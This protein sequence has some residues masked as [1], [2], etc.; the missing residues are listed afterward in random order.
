MNA[1]RAAAAGRGAVLPRQQ[2]RVEPQDGL[3]ERPLNGR[4][5]S[6]HFADV[7]GGAVAV[8]AEAAQNGGGGIAEEHGKVAPAQARQNGNVALKGLG[9]GAG[10]KAERARKKP[11]VRQ[12]QHAV[13]QLRANQILEPRPD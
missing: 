10:E 2:L 5:V 13:P 8:V 3:L 9:K 12:L 4:A 11:E 1:A 6:N 7:K